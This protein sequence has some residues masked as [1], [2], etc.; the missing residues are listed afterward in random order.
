MNELEIVALINDRFSTNYQFLDDVSYKHL[1]RFY[2]E[3]KLS[4]LLDEHPEFQVFMCDPSPEPEQE[5]YL[6][7]C[8]KCKVSFDYNENSE[9]PNCGEIWVPF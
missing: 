3:I 9:C 1:K 6:V 5:I 7:E 2:L 8:D 4:I